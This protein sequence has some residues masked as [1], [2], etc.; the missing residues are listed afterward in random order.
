MIET[1]RQ[2]EGQHALDAMR[3]IEGGLSQIRNGIVSGWA[4]DPSDPA[5]KVAL[6]A[7]IDGEL[8]GSFPADRIRPNH[9]ASDGHRTCGFKFRVPD[10]FLD[11]GVH[12]LSI[13]ATPGGQEIGESPMSF[14]SAPPAP[15]KRAVSA[16]PAKTAAPAEQETADRDASVSVPDFVRSVF[17][18]LAI[19]PALAA[20]AR[21]EILKRSGW[22]PPA[23]P[24]PA[25]SGPGMGRDAEAAL[26]LRLWIDIEA[27]APDAVEA[28]LASWALQ[29][30][31]AP[32][33]LFCSDPIEKS[34][35]AALGVDTVEPAE[36]QAPPAG[37]VVFA[38]AGDT[39]HP[40]LS[41]ILSALPASAAAAFWNQKTGRGGAESSEVRR[42]S[43]GAWPAAF[44]G[45]L[46]A[47]GFAVNASRLGGAFPD[48]PTAVV[49]QLRASGD[50]R[51][52]WLHLDMAL[53]KTSAIERRTRRGWFGGFPIEAVKAA[54]HLAAPGL[55]LEE[56]GDE[57]IVAPLCEPRPIAVVLQL[58]DEAQVERALTRLGRQQLDDRLE[59]EL[60]V[61]MDEP[62]MSARTTKEAAQR[63]PGIRVSVTPVPSLTGLPQACMSAAEQ[64]DS[65][66]YVLLR[67]GVLLTHS[68]SLELVAAWA[69]QEGVAAVTCR[70][71]LEGAPKTV[72]EDEEPALRLAAGC[73]RFYCAAISRRAWERVG[74]FDP[75]RFPNLWDVEWLLRAEAL[76]LRSL[77][78]NFLGVKCSA[79]APPGS[80]VERAWLSALYPLR[81]YGLGSP[82]LD[83]S[84]AADRRAAFLA[85][86]ML[87]ERRRNLHMRGELIKEVGALKVQVADMQAAVDVMAVKLDRA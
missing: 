68:R 44:V 5:F 75:S 74:P 79:P 62:K 41:E 21:A 15:A 34:R 4:W 33:V 71:S 39:F 78:L 19:E 85:Q 12:V 60:L 56:Y 69:E 82:D 59:L 26:D 16:E 14:S 65:Q 70:A 17:M 28:S 72:R 80:E 48:A 63:L 25:A 11:G 86:E 30:A 20:L 58:S 29:S 83:G 18:G 6:E 8:I 9:D 2:V 35:Y 42:R 50:I 7:C 3:T 36:L 87:S 77:H 76:G 52:P 55:K 22:V 27:A 23:Q 67:P 84:I 73:D 10:R 49:A 66:V 1:S 31:A 45:G 13:R 43:G 61:P 53:S 32:P 51:E 37:F 38:R 47:C 24:A 54:I 57:V 81:G 46:G 64:T 40:R